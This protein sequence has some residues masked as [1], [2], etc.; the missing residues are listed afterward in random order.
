MFIYLYSIL[1]D[2]FLPL[3]FPLSFRLCPPPPGTIE[4]A[5][6]F[7]LGHQCTALQPTHPHAFLDMNTA[8]TGFFVF[9][10]IIKPS[11]VSDKKDTAVF[12]MN[13]FLSTA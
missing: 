10:D 1:S 8:C 5:T 7:L 13:A 4:F 2:F 9:R 12:H 3:L 6:F 11:T